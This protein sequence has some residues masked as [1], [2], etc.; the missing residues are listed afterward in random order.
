M[1][2]GWTVDVMVGMVFWSYLC[3]G[4]TVDVKVVMVC[5]SLM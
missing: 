3:E 5:W 4:R 1:C 2:D